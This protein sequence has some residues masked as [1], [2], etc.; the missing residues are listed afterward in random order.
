[1]RSA[2]FW[3]SV[4][5]CLV[6]A[7]QV[8][9]CDAMHCVR[10]TY[11]STI[12]PGFWSNT[13]SAAQWPICSVSSTPRAKVAFQTSYRLVLSDCMPV[14]K[15]PEQMLG[16][17]EGTHST[18]AEPQQDVAVRLTKSLLSLLSALASHFRLCTVPYCQ[19]QAGKKASSQVPVVPFAA[20]AAL[21]PGNCSLGI[22]TNL[23]WGVATASYQVRQ[24]S[25][26]AQHSSSPRQQP[27][28]THRH[29]G[30]DMQLLCVLC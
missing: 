28:D 6:G 2:A 24:G 4:A 23:N 3:L 21:V 26:A 5:V 11:V 29:T 18:T 17:T 19:V 1:M 22:R 12:R 20:D 30:C 10:L 27:A 13:N 7:A 9:D 16:V 15:A 8:C 14:C 25:T